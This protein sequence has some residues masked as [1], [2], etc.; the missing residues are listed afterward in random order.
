MTVNDFD[1]IAK[2][3]IAEKLLMKRITQSLPTAKRATPIDTIDGSRGADRA[4]CP[5]CKREVELLSFFA[6]GL[7]VKA[8]RATID[9][10]VRSGC[11]HRLHNRF[12]NVMVCSKSLVESLA[13]GAAR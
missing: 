1:F 5:R 9:R 3:A 2:S 10:R 11:L 7:V 12:G 4:F 6:A 13:E 8:D